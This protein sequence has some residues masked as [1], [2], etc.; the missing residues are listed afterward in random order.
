MLML[1]SRELLNIML[2]L[3]LVCAY[4]VVKTSLMILSPNDLMAHET[5]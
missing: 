1:V 5:F 4:V 3:V 2:V